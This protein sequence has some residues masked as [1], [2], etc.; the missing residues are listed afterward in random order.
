[1]TRRLR[2]VRAGADL[3]VA[4]LTVVT[5]MAVLLALGLTITT[6]SVNNL[7][8]ASRDRQAGAALAASDA[9]VAQAIE[10]IRNNGV[11]GLNCVEA[12]AATT[13]A[14]NPAGWTNPTSPQQIPLTSGTAGCTASTDCATVWIGTVQAYAPPLVKTGIYRI[15]SKGI[16]GN[17]P[18]ARNVVVDVSVT[19]DNF[20]VGVFGER[21]SGN[22][23]TRIFFESLFA[24]DCV[25]PRQTGSGN[26]T[27]FSGID[28]FWGIPAAAHTTSHVSTANNCGSRGYIHQQSGNRSCPDQNGYSSSSQLA[29]LKFDRSGDGGPVS[30]GSPCYRSFQKA[31]GTWYPEND[32]TAFTEADLQRYGYR[33][34][35]L[36][37][38]Q[39]SALKARAQSQ[40]LYNI[41]TGSISSA[42]SAVVASGIS[43]P[44]LYWDNGSNVS[45]SVNDFPANTFN[46]APDTTC[47]SRAV[48]VVVEHANLTFQGGNS[49]WFNGSFFVPDGSWT[50][51]GG[52]NIVGTMWANNVSLG[53]NEQWQLDQ[54]YVQ[55]MPGPILDVRAISFREDD[56]RDN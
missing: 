7:Q 48:V 49:G 13:C 18:G 45:L 35:G 6:I 30:A 9:G 16:Y 3:G 32:T 5:V 44:V 19:P 17:G 26:G 43:Q 53:G 28:P 23:G 34:R 14:S 24:R 46:R 2:L 1:M 22:G 25:S 27:R 33:P 11:G 31:D 50:G 4:M 15:H 37:D 55:N 41:S 10:Y 8:N 29:A 12:T 36:S 40:N 39:Y 42:I 52:Y 56:S 20:P 54:C 51:N 47:S 21:I 38:A